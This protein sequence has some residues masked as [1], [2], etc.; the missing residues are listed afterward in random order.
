M[1]YNDNNVAEIAWKF[2]Y[3]LNNMRDLKDSMT[4]GENRA[5][6]Y[7]TAY[8]S[9]KL[10]GEAPEVLKKRLQLERLERELLEYSINEVK[11]FNFSFQKRPTPKAD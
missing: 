10:L 8:V 5:N 1:G 3:L 6:S 9:L 2:Y 4:P 11:S 7:H